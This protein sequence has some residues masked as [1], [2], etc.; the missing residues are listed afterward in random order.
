MH[1]RL[2]NGT[3]LLVGGA[4]HLLVR[5][6]AWQGRGVGRR[7]HAAVSG[8]MAA[9]WRRDGGEMAARWRRDGEI[10]WHLGLGRARTWECSTSCSTAERSISGASPNRRAVRPAWTLA[11]VLSPD[12]PTQRCGGGGNVAGAV[13]SGG[14]PPGSDFARACALA[15]TSVGRYSSS[16]ITVSCAE[17][18]AA[19]GVG[20]LARLACRCDARSEGWARAWPR[21]GD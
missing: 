8:E 5:R 19:L 18:A 12:W 17:G 16:M 11:P 13:A 21:G 6:V 20:R 9:R 3:D 1:E 10:G 14:A 15:V 7:W 2:G 4:H